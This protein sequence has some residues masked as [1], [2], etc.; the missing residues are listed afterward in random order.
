[1]SEGGE[2]EGGAAAA[3]TC[4]LENSRLPHGNRKNNR[5]PAA[6]DVDRGP[7]ALVGGWG[8]RQNL[9]IYNTKMVLKFRKN[10]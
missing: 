9:V 3:A 7:L 1:L 8:E 6:V 5:F 10:E 2:E 4:R